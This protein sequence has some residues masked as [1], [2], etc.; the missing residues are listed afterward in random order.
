MTDT[1]DSLS[2]VVPFRFTCQRSGRCC[3]VG[4]GY[5]WLQ[6]NELEGLARATG[7][8]AEAFTRECVRRV[9]DPRTGELRLA[10]REG[11]GLQA[12]RCRLLDGH[13]ECTVYESRPAHCR[14]F[15]F[16]PSVLG[17][18]HGFERARQVCPGIRVEPTPENREAAFRALAAL[19]DELQKEIDAIGPAC[20]M[21]GLCCRFEEAGH[22]LFAGALE[23]DYARTMHPDPPEPEAPGRCPYHV[24]GRCTAREGRPLACRTYFCDKPKE[25][26]CMD[27]HEAFLV[28]LRG[29]EDAFGY[30]RTYARF[31][32]LL[33]QYLKP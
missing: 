30:E 12:D 16:W 5:V 7:M 31:P 26:A 2:G 33:A 6:E 4:A 21:S 25:D 3:R 14:D 27:L 13:N 24:Q 28:R 9:V 23:T 8:E 11:T 22:E 18:A 15:P 20:A 17:S 29:I 10:L 19:Y 1:S 32:Q